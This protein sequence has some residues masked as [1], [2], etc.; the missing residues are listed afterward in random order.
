MARLGHCAFV[1]VVSPE[2]TPKAKSALHDWGGTWEMKRDGRGCGVDGD[3]AAGEPVTVLE[4]RFDAKTL[5]IASAEVAETTRH[6]GMPHCEATALLRFRDLPGFVED[7][8]RE[9]TAVVYG[10]HVEDLTVLGEAIGLTCK[11][12]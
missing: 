12:F 9:H 4:L 7:I 6:M 5:L 3:L 1:G 10:D 8:S 2:M 11:V